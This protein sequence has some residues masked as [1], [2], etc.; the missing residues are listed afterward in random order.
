[1][2]IYALHPTDKFFGGYPEIQ[3]W[4][5]LAALP[6]P[7]LAFMKECEKQNRVYTPEEFQMAVNKKEI[8]FKNV[9]IFIKK[10]E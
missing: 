4:S 6:E 5:T 2:K 8:D 1:M 10:H 7:A 3:Q 9:V